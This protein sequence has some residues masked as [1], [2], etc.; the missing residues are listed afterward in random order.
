MPI[1]II[2]R[3]HYGVGKRKEVMKV[4]HPFSVSVKSTLF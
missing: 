1:G 3:E 2:E 4:N